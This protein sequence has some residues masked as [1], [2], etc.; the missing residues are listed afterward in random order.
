MTN[1]VT[2][3]QNNDFNTFMKLYFLY[4]PK[5][6][7]VNDVT[8]KDPHLLMG[9]TF[10]M[11]RPLQSLKTHWGIFKVCFAATSLTVHG[12]CAFF[13]NVQYCEFCKKF[14]EKIESYQSEKQRKIWK[15]HSKKKHIHI[16]DPESQLRVLKILNWG[17]A[18]QNQIRLHKLFAPNLYNIATTSQ[19]FDLSKYLNAV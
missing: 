10:S 2:T 17:S 16:L 11:E 19:A 4:A 14:W 12:V 18:V 1:V 8:R 5:L 15:S 6:W 7:A 3:I 13:S 9:L